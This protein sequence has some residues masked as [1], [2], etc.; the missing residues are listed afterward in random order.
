MHQ[1]QERSEGMALSQAGLDI[2]V[3]LLLLVLGQDLVRILATVVRS[4]SICD[5]DVKDSRRS[6]PPESVNANVATKFWRWLC[7]GSCCPRIVAQ[8]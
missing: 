5:A 1:K 7:A 6:T 3:L 4:V 2:L 8:I